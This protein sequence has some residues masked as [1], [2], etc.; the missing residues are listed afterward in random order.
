MRPG[1]VMVDHKPDMP[2]VSRLILDTCTA[3]LA[4]V[5]VALKDAGALRLRYAVEL[6]GASW[7]RVSSQPVLALLQV[8]V[9]VVRLNG[10]A[11]VAPQFANAPCPLGPVAANR[12]L[13]LCR[14]K[15]LSPCWQETEP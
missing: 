10:P 12:R 3:C 11:L 8:G 7:R 1:F 4:R 5:A 13:Q 14:R 6:I 9:V 2:T 15:H